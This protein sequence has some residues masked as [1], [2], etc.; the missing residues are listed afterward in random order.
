MRIGSDRSAAV[1]HV[2]EVEV[3]LALVVAAGLEEIVAEELD[4]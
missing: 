3:A 1:S 2:H 4:A